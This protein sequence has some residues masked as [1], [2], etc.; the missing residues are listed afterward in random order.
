[1][2]SRFFRVSLSN[3]GTALIESE[4]ITAFIVTPSGVCKVYIKGDAVPFE[5]KPASF[6]SL[7]CYVA[8]GNI[9][10]AS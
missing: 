4:S 8:V 3:G 6:E 7:R 1:M 2:S 5:L 9:V 10:D